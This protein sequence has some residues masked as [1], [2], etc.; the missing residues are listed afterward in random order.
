[1]G[2]SRLS[3]KL[4]GGYQSG[5]QPTMCCCCPD[6]ISALF[7]L[8]VKSGFSKSAVAGALTF[9]PPDPPLYQFR[10]VDRDGRVLEEEEEE[11]AIEDF[12]NSD[13]EEGDNSNESGHGGGGR[14]SWENGVDNTPGA[15]VKNS[16]NVNDG[17]EEYSAIAD[18]QVPVESG[19]QLNGYGSGGSGATGD[20]GPAEGE[21]EEEAVV[22]GPTAFSGY[23]PDEEDLKRGAGRNSPRKQDPTSPATRSGAGAESDGEG[24]SRQVSGRD[25][26]GERNGEKSRRGGESDGDGGSRRGGTSKKKGPKKKQEKKKK[27]KPKSA[28]AA[29]T[30]RSI[31]LRRRARTRNTRDA[32][33]ASVGVTHVFVPDPRLSAAPRFGGTYEAIK[34]GP[35]KKTGSYV[36]ALIY[37][38]RTDAV[39]HRTKTIIYS[40]GNAT[41]I[42]GMSYMQAVLAGCLDVNVVM[43][44]Y[45]GYGASGGVPLEG[46]TYRDVKLVF[47][48]TVQNICGGDESKV[49]FY[50]QSIG[51]GPSCYLCSKRQGVGGLILHSP[52]TS[53]MRVLTPSRALACLDIFPNI[54]RMS[55]V[56]C[57]VMVI[58]GGQ[59]EEVDVAHGMALHQAVQPE[60][61]REPWWVPDRGHNDI[62]DGPGKMAEYVRRLRRFLET[63]A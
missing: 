4:K 11:E 21:N 33:D 9:F 63:L 49:V 58:H 42:G 22:S 37:R 8:W 40:H 39:H 24:G 53:G 52:F 32:N 61:R 34:I 10:R 13:D 27:T 14:D 29:L 26:E 31:R 5:K 47:D 38:A 41:D 6:A 18:E 62:T 19:L 28:A 60:L 1:M 48:Y 30:E 36:A 50:G 46:N 43:Y 17:E 55:K 54:D 25:S 7:C 3:N 56:R 12:G 44:D 51:S 57:P 16:S 20:D 23:G 45:S 2:P 35:Q 15:V 59:D